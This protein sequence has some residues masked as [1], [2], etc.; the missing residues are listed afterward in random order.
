MRIK[1]VEWEINYFLKD[2]NG[3]FMIYTA[4][5]SNPIIPRIGERF[6]LFVDKKLIRMRC[7]DVFHSIGDDQIEVY[8]EKI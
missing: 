7:V 4:Q 5:M 2:Q 3:S 8:G 1:I 6:D